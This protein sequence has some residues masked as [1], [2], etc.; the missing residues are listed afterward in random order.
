LQVDGP[1]QDFRLARRAS[2]GV[3]Q[4]GRQ[5][6]PSSIQHCP[7]D[8]DLSVGTPFLHVVDKF[9]KFFGSQLRQTVGG[10]YSAGV[11]ARSHSQEATSVKHVRRHEL[12]DQLQI[13]AKLLLL[14]FVKIVPS[15]IL[16]ELSVLLQLRCQRSPPWSKHVQEFREGQIAFGRQRWL[17]DSSFTFTRIIGNRLAATFRRQ[18]IVDGDRAEPSLECRFS[19]IRADLDQ[20]LEERFLTMVLGQCLVTSVPSAQS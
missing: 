5:G 8:E 19:P 13:A 10:T 17:I 11:K 9:I 4:P 18:N 15:P 2:N 14:P 20:G 12:L 6:V 3:C 1:K 16:D 7:T